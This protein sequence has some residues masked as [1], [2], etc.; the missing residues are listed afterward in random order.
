[1]NENQISFKESRSDK[2]DNSIWLFGAWMGSRYND[3]PKELFEYVSRSC[4]QIEA[5]WV[6][7]SPVIVNEIKSKGFKVVSWGSEL[8]ESLLL[9]AG[10]LVYCIYEADVADEKDYGKLRTANRLHTS[11]GMPIKKSYMDAPEAIRPSKLQLLKKQINIMLGRNGKVFNICTSDF[12]RPITYS[13]FLNKN[14]LVLGTPRLDICFSKKESSYISNLRKKFPDG[15]KFILYMPTFRN[16]LYDGVPFSPFTQYGFDFAAMNDMLERHNMVFLNKAHFYDNNI[17]DGFNSERF[18]SVPNDP[19]LD[20]YDILKDIDI[21][22]TDYSSIYTDFAIL[23]KPMI[24]TPF[25]YND[26]IKDYRGLYF[27]YSEWESKTVYN[28]PDFIS[29]IDNKD[30]W[31]LPQEKVCKY[32]K[33][34]DGNSSERITKAICKRLKIKF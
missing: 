26:Y 7:K 19:I 24:L 17:D 27:D 15:V 14:I 31:S 25:D 3:N 18:I 6:T 5:Y 29:A 1:M 22:V 23:N 32:H 34:I 30:Y 28:W 9:R 33:F 16:S 11:H 2:R 12:F 10:V 21:L 8:H 4:P 13:Q 20:I